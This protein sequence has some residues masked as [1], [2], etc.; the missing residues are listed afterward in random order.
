MSRL[1][2]ELSGDDQRRA[3]FVLAACPSVDLPAGSE[4]RRGDLPAATL[5][6]VEVGAVLV[7]SERPGAAR[8]MV[9]ALAAPGSVLV[10]PTDDER[11]AALADARLTALTP[12]AH[13]A[14]LLEPPTAAAIA[15]ALIEA[16]YDRQGSL[17]NFGRFP[18]VERVRAKLLDLACSHGKVAE[19]GV[20]IDLPLTHDLLAEMIGSARETVTL[21]LRE[22]TDSGFI[23]RN[24]QLY[25]LGIS[26]A[27][28]ALQSRR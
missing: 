10:P 12:E 1:L 9:V 4:Q 11:F 28:L 16:V 5:F 15:N 18:H 3:R 13:R 26:P 7:V 27:E 6:V 2:L 24:G 23:S 22:L 8:R 21:A 20:Y 19:G 14:L 17:A 25:R